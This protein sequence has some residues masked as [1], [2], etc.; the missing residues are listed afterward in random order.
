MIPSDTRLALMDR[1]SDLLSAKQISVATHSLFIRHVRRHDIDVR[2][3][4][5]CAD[6]AATGSLT[7]HQA[8]S[9]AGQLVAAALLDRRVHTRRGRGDKQVV[10]YR[11]L[12]AEG[13]GQ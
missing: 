11:L 5:S 10:K 8:R 2:E 1:A 12:L 6:L 4:H 13:A 9:A 7:H 3:W